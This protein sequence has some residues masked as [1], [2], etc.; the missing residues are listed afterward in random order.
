M[1]KYIAIISTIYHCGEEWSIWLGWKLIQ[2]YFQQMLWL[3][4]HVN[5]IN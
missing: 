5:L 3:I 2:G 1:F 4:K